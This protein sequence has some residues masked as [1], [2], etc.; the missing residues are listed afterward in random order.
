MRVEDGTDSETSRINVRITTMRMLGS[1]SFEPSTVK[2]AFYRID[3]IR[4]TS[5]VTLPR[6]AYNIC[7]YMKMGLQLRTNEKTTSN[8][9]GGSK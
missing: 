1:A 3:I 6:L 4:H 9:I 5:I 7:I 2:F 8:Q